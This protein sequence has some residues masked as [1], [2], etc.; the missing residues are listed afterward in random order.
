MVESAVHVDL[1]IFTPNLLAM[2]V[3]H[4]DS[5]ITLSKNERKLPRALGG[6]QASHEVCSKRYLKQ[7]KVNY[8]PPVP[9]CSTKKHLIIKRVSEF[10]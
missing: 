3:K 1:D 2:F 10:P 6:T 5:F 9:A 4:C 7:L 8:P